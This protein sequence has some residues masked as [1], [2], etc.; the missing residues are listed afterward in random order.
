MPTIA[1]IGAGPLGGV[2]A[3]TLAARNRVTAVQLI[4]PEV[5]VAEG[6]AL[7]ILQA[8][9]IEQFSTR[10]TAA[11]TL[12]AAGGAD[13]IVLADLVTGGEISGE[14]GLALVRQLARLEASAPIV[15]AGGAQRELMIRTHAELHVAARR[16]VGSAP[17]ALESSIRAL[18][19]ALIDASPV[20]LSIGVAGVPPR[21]AVIGWDAATAFGQPL[22]AILAAHHMA[23]LSTRL[24]ALW[25]PSPY[26]S[27]S[28]A[29][30]VA[31]AIA[32]GS[33]RRY[34]SFAVLERTSAGPN[35]VA[36]VPVAF[37]RGGVGSVLEP[38]LSR[39]ERVAFENGL[40]G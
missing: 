17:L 36:A 38:A 39:H 11:G 18:V 29:A 28:A 15:F 4:D 26:T 20:D 33:R 22:A 13:A 25:P 35:R 1:V 8:S 23:A 7:D 24:L 34:V 16:L 21:H 19:A 32:L 12:A 37:V 27:A 5:K 40:A 14:S 30:R 31:E 10:L 2:L 6:K 3:H 9:P